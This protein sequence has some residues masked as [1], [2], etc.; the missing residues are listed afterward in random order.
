MSCEGKQKRVN[1]SV[2]PE[3]GGRMD[4]GAER[5]VSEMRVQWRAPVVCCIDYYYNTR[6]EISSNIGLKHISHSDEVRGA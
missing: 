1:S 5:R 3:Y 6:T 2:N 4:T